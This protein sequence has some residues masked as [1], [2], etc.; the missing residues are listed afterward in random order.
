MTVLRSSPCFT[1]CFDLFDLGQELT[2]LELH[3]PRRSYS[4]S[5]GR[6]LSL[7]G[8][9]LER[10]LINLNMFDP[11]LVWKWWKRWEKWSWYPSSQQTS[12]VLTLSEL[13]C[14]AC[15]HV[16]SSIFSKRYSSVLSTNLRKYRKHWFAN[17]FLPGCKAKSRHFL[18]HIKHVESFST[19]VTYPLLEAGYWPS[20]ESVIH[21]GIYLTANGVLYREETLSLERFRL[22]IFCSSSI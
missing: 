10:P 22:S 7:P 3:W 20:L 4:R 5:A 18:R 6:N 19:E 15:M 17:R 16:Q 8:V 13:L 11:R 12:L 21:S 14:V 1:F 9:G 2:L